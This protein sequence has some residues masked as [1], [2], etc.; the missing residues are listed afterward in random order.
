MKKVCLWG[1]FC[2][3]FLKLRWVILSCSLLL[4]IPKMLYCAM[5]MFV[6][7]QVATVLQK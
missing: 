7:I 6:A 5:V 2:V 4:D 1:P 3:P